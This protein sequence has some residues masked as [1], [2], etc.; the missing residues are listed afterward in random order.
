MPLELS[1]YLRS[2]FPHMNFTKMRRSPSEWPFFY[3]WMVLFVGALGVLMTAPGQT[4]GVSAFTDPL[5]DALKLSRDQLSISYMG[6]TVLSALMLT[7]AGQLF[8][9]F[10]AM[11]TAFV[12]SIGLGVALIFMSQTD[13][14][15]SLFGDSYIITMIIVFFGFVFIRF[16]G[17]G[18]LTLAS[19]TMVVKWFD[20]R[21]GLA[22]GVLSVVTA[23]GFS[24]APKVFDVMIGN[25]GWSGAWQVMA[26][27][28][29]LVFPVLVYL[30]YKSGP[31]VYG[32]KPDGL[33][34]SKQRRVK[35]ARFPV[36]RDYTLNEARSTL[37]LW[38]FSGLV[39]LYGLVITGLTFHI[40]SIFAEKGLDK[41]MAI[42]V[43]QPL[44]FVAVATTLVSSPLS[45]YIKMKYLA[46]VF[47]VAGTFGMFSISQLGSADVFYYLVIVSFGI[48]SG[49]HPLVVT[50]FL[51][52]FFGKLHLG[53]ITG[54][55]MTLMVFASAFGPILF[56]QSLSITGSY[57]FAAY[58]CGGTFVF[59]L[60]FA[61]MTKNP[62]LEHA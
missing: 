35:P 18:V 41:D 16:F 2:T 51:P 37:S 25:Y 40:V 33:S 30:F 50:L 31:E 1:L 38:V 42:N 39:A 36:H 46:F 21:R 52:R 55:A 59:L 47:C 48:C 49:I 9:R 19:R 29:G 57:N 56:S 34:E 62:Q 53:A 32:L 13:R 58:L 15:A 43:F 61:I 23:F 27:Y 8:D 6:G 28:I 3:G 12:A 26:L 11:K 4:I 45:D 14:L 54:Q 10:G 20:A 24:L 7:K 60:A 17:Q 44:A 5:I 22:V